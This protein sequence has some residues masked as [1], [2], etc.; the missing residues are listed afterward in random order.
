MVRT[1]CPHVHDERKFAFFLTCLGCAIVCLGSPRPPATAFNR[2][3][4]GGGSAWLD[5]TEIEVRPS[6]GSGSGGICQIYLLAKTL[7]DL[8]IL[9]LSSIGSSYDIGTLLYSPASLSSYFPPEDDTTLSVEG[10][11]CMLQ[12]NSLS[13]R[14]TCRCPP[15]VIRWRW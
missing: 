5:S 6:P 10:A 13:C 15:S 14:I 1:R 3:G 8:F 12:C 11:K 9:C 4:A 7:L 2:M